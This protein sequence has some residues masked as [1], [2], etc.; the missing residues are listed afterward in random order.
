MNRAKNHKLIKP[1]ASVPA[2][3]YIQHATCQLNPSEA[4]SRSLEPGLDVE[5]AS[6]LLQHFISPSDNRHLQ[7]D[8]VSSVLSF[9]SVLLSKS[10]YVWS[11]ITNI[12]RTPSAWEQCV[13]ASYTLK[14]WPY[15]LPSSVMFTPKPTCKFTTSQTVNR[16]QLI[17]CKFP[18]LE[19]ITQL[20]LAVYSAFA[21]LHKTW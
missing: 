15:F 6:P 16:R 10:T 11:N 20:L 21:S 13:T 14:Y 1:L 9:N 8:C 2:R 19:I 18:S 4:R 12:N 17:N 7:T 5:A 3:Q